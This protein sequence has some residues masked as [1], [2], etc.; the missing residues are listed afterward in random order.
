MF[1][2]TLSGWPQTT[3]SP[4]YLLLRLDNQLCKSSMDLSICSISPS[5]PGMCC[6]LPTKSLIHLWFP[7]PSSI[8][9][10]TK[11]QPGPFLF[12]MFPYALH[13][14]A[15]P[16]FWL[17]RVLVTTCEYHSGTW[18]VSHHHISGILLD[19]CFHWDSDIIIIVKEIGKQL[20]NET[21]SY[22]VK[23]VLFSSI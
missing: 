6:I 8:Q 23:N 9:S 14:H 3:P 18:V 20:S 11:E 13:A 15:H 21:Y 10:L 4:V 1:S 19:H 5:L 22:E 17:R 2:L 12:W 16:S 7:L